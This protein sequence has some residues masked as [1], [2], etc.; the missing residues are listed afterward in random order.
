L[1]KNPKQLLY[2]RL[3]DGSGKEFKALVQRQIDGLASL[4]C[5][6]CKVLLYGLVKIYQGILVLNPENCQV[7]D[8]AVLNLRVNHPIEQI[9]KI[10]NKQIPTTNRPR[11]AV[12]FAAASVMSPISTTPQFEA[13]NFASPS[14]NDLRSYVKKLE[15][16]NRRL[17]DQLKESEERKKRAS[18]V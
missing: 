15:E 9:S 14:K 3:S 18:K 1:F 12:S 17:K 4:T 13:K 5:P 16:E 10:L 6:G 11:P 8:G 2:I 7:L